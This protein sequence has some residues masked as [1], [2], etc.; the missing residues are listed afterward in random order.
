VPADMPDVEV[1]EAVKQVLVEELKL[2]PDV[3]RPEADLRLDLGLDSL[4]VATVAMALEERLGIEV[5]DE[6]MQ[7][8]ETVQ[9][10]V[11]FLA[12][13]IPAGDRSG[14]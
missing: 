3:V 4:D 11:T 7:N 6:A 10:A 9:D 5:S 12:A 14:S 8:V 13:H 1:Y 2:S